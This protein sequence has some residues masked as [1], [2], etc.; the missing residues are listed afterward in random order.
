MNFTTEDV[1]RVLDQLMRSIGFERGY[2]AQ[3]GDIGSRIAR[4]LAVDYPSCKGKPKT[5][6]CLDCT[7]TDLLG[8][9]SP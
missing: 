6:S 4:N 5:T 1:S 9:R 2:V 7:C 3:G 8:S